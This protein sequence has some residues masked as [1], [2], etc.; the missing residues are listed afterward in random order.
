[1]CVTQEDAEGEV[2][3]GWKG[4]A[5]RWRKGSILKYT[6][7]TETFESSRWAALVAG[8]AV[9]AIEMWKDVGIRFERVKRDEEATFAIKYCFEPDNC[10][11]DVYARAFF[12]KTSRG[13]LLVYQLALEPANVD[14][15]ANILAHELGHVLGLSHEFADQTSFLWG[16][17]NDRSVMNYF[18]D[19]NQL[20]VGQQDREELTSYYECDAGRYKG[21][22]ITD[23]EPRLY[24]F[25]RDAKPSVRR[26]RSASRRLYLNYR[27]RHVRFR[28]GPSLVQ[29]RDQQTKP[30]Q[31]ALSPLLIRCYCGFVLF[32]SFACY[33]LLVGRTWA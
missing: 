23:I 7:C 29:K 22:T 5:T 24:H 9:K 33:S 21:L 3:V 10:R 15:L 14:F 13:E 11:P 16:K 2:R 31:V 25:P 6:V 28:R 18:S 30:S 27:V 32:A 17:N 19:L 4:Y 26:R 12:P 8:E 20:Q 1:M